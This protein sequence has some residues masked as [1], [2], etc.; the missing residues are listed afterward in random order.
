MQII[1]ENKTLENSFIE[2]ADFL[3]MDTK[4]LLEKVIKDFII[5]QELK[6]VDKI[7]KNIKKEYLEVLD[8]RKNGKQLQ[9]LESLLDEL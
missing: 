9:T 8:A 1:I 2:L 7:A 5:S 4:L 6:K 3:K